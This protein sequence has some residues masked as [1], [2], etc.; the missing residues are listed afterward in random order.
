VTFV[1]VVGSAIALLVW[2]GILLD[3]L[4]RKKDRGSNPRAA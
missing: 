2:T 3:W 1:L 4:A